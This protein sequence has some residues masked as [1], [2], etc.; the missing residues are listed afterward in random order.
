MYKENIM[1]GYIYE[2]TNLINGKTYIGKKQGKFD[3]TYYGSG[4]ILQQA[5]KKYGR[6]NFEVVV[7]STSTINNVQCLKY[8]TI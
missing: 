3:K 2:T 5:L 4:M 8:Y 1:F 7:L 6:K